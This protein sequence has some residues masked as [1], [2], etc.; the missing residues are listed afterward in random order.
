[1]LAMASGKTKKCINQIE[2][3]RGIVKFIINWIESK[4][5]V[6]HRQLHLHLSQ[7]YRI[8]RPHPRHL[9]AIIIIVTVRAE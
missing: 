4:V 9:N 2:Y 5:G 3:E 7:Q 6:R 1:M 8:P